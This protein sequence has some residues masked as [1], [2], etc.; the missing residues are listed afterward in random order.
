V[1]AKCTQKAPQSP[2]LGMVGAV[3]GMFL[4]KV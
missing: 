1:Y 3:Y 4:L 2:P